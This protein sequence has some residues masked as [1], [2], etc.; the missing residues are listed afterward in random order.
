LFKGLGGLANI[1]AVIKQAQQMGGR[2][3]TLNN[4]LRV[5]RATGSAGGG[6]IEV[7]MNGL[8]E[9][10]AVRIDQTLIARGDKEMIEDLL[11]S[12]F[13][14]AHL[15]A[16]ELHAEA[17]QSMTAELNLPGLSEALNQLGA[18]ETESDEEGNAN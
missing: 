6:L 8:A 11:P 18:G 9:V 15:K 3:K 14:A 16:K 5:K 1:G 4:E 17:M 10:L 2:L 12:A 13:N 7:D